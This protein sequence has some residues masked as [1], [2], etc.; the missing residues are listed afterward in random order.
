MR[1]FD[2]GLVCDKC[3]CAVPVPN[4]LFVPNNH[5]H[6]ILVTGEQMVLCDDSSLRFGSL[7]ASHNEIGPEVN[8]RMIDRRIDHARRKRVSEMSPEEMRQALLVSEKTGLPNRRAFDESRASAWVAMCDVNGLKSLND[9]FGYS[10]GD[11]L[12][13]RLAEVL[14]GVGLDAYHDKGDEFLCRGDSYQELNHKLSLAQNSLHQQPFIVCGLDGRITSVPGA[15][16]C[17][18]IGTNLEEAERSLK[19]QKELRKLQR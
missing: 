5:N 9:G 16:F 10:A 4:E 17:F 1:A 14:V 13:R 6:I 8:R 7:A 19:H 12:I 3:N 2:P 18:G 15:D 11:I